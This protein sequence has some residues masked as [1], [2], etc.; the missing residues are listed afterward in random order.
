[1]AI[2]VLN[3]IAIVRAEA[4]KP[5]P[6]ERADPERIGLWGHSMGGG[7]STRVMVVSPYVKAV[8]LYGA[9]SGDEAKNYERINT[10]FSGGTRGL[11]ELRV[12]PEALPRISPIYFLNRVAAAVSIHH[13]EADP[14][15]PPPWSN[16]LC[17]RLRD[18]NKTVECFVY[19]GQGHTFHD[20]G[21][22]LFMQRMIDFY[23]RTLAAP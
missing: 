15:V 2:D 8:V 18:L 22:T 11:E 9:M 23:R 14:D 1:M 10:Y 12:P 3:L 5:G 21:D 17:R 6:L 4:G 19:K 13:G 20:E 16:D 7:I